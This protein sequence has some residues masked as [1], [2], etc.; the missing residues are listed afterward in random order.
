MRRRIQRLAYSSMRPDRLM[1]GH[2][3]SLHPYAAPLTLHPRMLIFVSGNI[4]AAAE[5]EGNATWTETLSLTT[6]V[7]TCLSGYVGSPSRACLAEGVFGD[8]IN[9]CTRTLYFLSP[10]LG[11]INIVRSVHSS[12][13]LAH[14][15]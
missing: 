12:V 5:N 14:Q 1:G 8:V 6:A 15:R 3:E 9:P 10:G 13:L 11:Y 2:H 4:C 7:G